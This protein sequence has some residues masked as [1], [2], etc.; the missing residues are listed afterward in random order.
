[1]TASRVFLALMGCVLILAGLFRYLPVVLIHQ[2]KYLRVRA[3]CTGYDRRMA[4]S[5]NRMQYYPMFRFT[6]Q[7]GLLVN[8]IYNQAG[9]Q[10]KTDREYVIYYRQDRPHV[11]YCPRDRYRALWMALFMGFGILLLVLA[12]LR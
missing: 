4:P 12:A 5:D 10:F 9:R 2:G 1:M 6:A 7:S 3:V 11:I 8:A